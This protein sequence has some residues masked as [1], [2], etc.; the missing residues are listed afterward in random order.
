[1]WAMVH[2]LSQ[3]NNIKS[4]ISS[5]DIEKEIEDILCSIEI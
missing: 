5:D 1:M 3:A 2:G 4:I